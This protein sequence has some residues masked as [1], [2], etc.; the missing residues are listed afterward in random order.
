[1][2]EF[3]VQSMQ[4]APSSLPRFRN[5]LAG[6]VLLGACLALCSMGLSWMVEPL[7]RE[8]TVRLAG[9]ALFR[10]GDWFQMFFM[11][12]LWSPVFETLAGQWLP[13]SLLRRFSTSTAAGMAAGAIVFSLVH[14]MNGGGW[15]QGVITGMSGA[16]FS[17]R[18]IHGLDYGMPGAITL[19]AVAHASNNAL[20]LCAAMLFG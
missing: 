6:A 20:C 18:Y 11:A 16:V 15:E 13:I 7:L 8:R 17:W 2:Q 10:S 4:W 1:M 9:A 3:A 5:A 12:V 19:T 14:M